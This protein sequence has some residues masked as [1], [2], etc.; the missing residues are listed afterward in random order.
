MR[1]AARWVSTRVFPDPGPASTKTGPA[2][3]VTAWRCWGLS[4]SRKSMQERGCL[5]GEENP[6]RDRGRSF[7]FGGAVGTASGL[8]GD[9]GK[10]VRAFPGGRLGN[11]RCGFFLQR[12]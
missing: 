6:R 4:L 9:G 11:D 2:P 7:E 10:A 1:Y 3:A 5:S 12:V 8:D